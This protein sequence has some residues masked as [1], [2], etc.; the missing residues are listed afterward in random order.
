MVSRRD[1]ARVHGAF[2]LSDNVTRQN[3][4]RSF[5]RPALHCFESPRVRRGG[6]PHRSRNAAQN[7]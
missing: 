1:V 7:V 2:A 3:A 6:D 4:G 5:D